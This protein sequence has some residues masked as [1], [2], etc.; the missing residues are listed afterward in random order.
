A[1]LGVYREQFGTVSGKYEGVALKRLEALRDQ[2]GQ[3]TPKLVLPILSKN[4]NAHEMTAA[5][6]FKSVL[7]K[8]AEALRKNDVYGRPATFDPSDFS[9][10]IDAR[11]KTRQLETCKKSIGQELG[12]LVNEFAARVPSDSPAH[13]AESAG[14][15]DA[16]RAYIGRNQ[17]R[18]VSRT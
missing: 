13:V 4:A 17:P 18:G 8:G 10:E 15:T 5:M 3:G 2:L 1:D 9:Y 14:V 16:I 12:Q 7:S 11:A 6:F